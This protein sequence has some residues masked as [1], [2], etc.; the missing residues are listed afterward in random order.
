VRAGVL[1]P[2]VVATDRVGLDG[3]VEAYRRMADRLT[4]KTLIRP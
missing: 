2:S 1:D 3:A 4:L